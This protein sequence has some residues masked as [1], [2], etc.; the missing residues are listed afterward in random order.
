MAVRLQYLAH[1]LIVP[2]GRFIIG[3]SSDCQLSLED[4]LVSRHHAAI[5]VELGR[6]AVEDLNSRN[7]VFVND[8]KITGERQLAAG[9]RLKIGS[10]ELVIELSLIREPMRT[11]V[12]DETGALS[13]LRHAELQEDDEE[14]ATYV[15]SIAELRSSISDPDRRVN[16]LSLIGG[17]ADKALA[18]GHIAEAERILSGS[19]HEILAKLPTSGPMAPE[20]IE[21]AGF[22]A[23]H[24]AA[25]TESGQWVDYVFEL[26]SAA[27]RLMPARLVDE[28]YA[29]A[30]KV[31]SVNKS[32]VR[33]YVAKI[34]SDIVVDGP[35]ERFLQQRIEGLERLLALK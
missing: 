10:Q 22:Y 23:S 18:L 16:A 32:K 9:D 33:Q 24:L 11:M 2:L 14:A 13:T 25:A 6:V 12:A 30:R 31:R 7:G 15:G 5:T 29:V 4:P 27:R 21:R 3:R 17:V 34:G 8:E 19:L 35:N 28:L 26:F 20:L 1:D